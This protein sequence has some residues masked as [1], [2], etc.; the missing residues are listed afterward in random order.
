[1]ARAI[2]LP[3]V[4]IQDIGKS[5]EQIRLDLAIFFYLAWRMPAGRCADYA[6]IS[7]VAF[8]N[9]LGQ[10]DIPIN[11]GLEALEQ[12]RKNWTTFLHYDDRQR[13]HL[14]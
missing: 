12:D 8:L 9:E 4:D 7:K 1:M 14:S 5:E 3:E 10:R 13:H 11:Y 2:T 6:G